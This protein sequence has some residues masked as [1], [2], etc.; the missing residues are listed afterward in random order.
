M[1]RLPDWERLLSD[2]L[3]SMHAAEYAYGR[4]D[5]GLF[6]A[7]AVIAITGIDPAG[8]FRGRYTTAR[9]AARALRRYGA[10]NLEKTLDSLF[11]RKEPA[12]AHR[13]DLVWNGE[14]VGVCAG[15]Y[16]L[17]IAAEGQDGGL[18]RVQRADLRGAW[19]V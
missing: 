10:G 14:A 13:G 12:F 3:A 6:A 16:A 11:E 1:N 19:A 4:L 8:P 9:G 2:Y 15:G 17:F 7:G 5:C 18:V